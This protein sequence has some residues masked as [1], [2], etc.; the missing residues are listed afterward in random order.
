MTL[1]YKL[2]FQSLGGGKHNKPYKDGMQGRAHGNLLQANKSSDSLFPFHISERKEKH[3]QGNRSA[4]IAGHQLLWDRA[5]PTCD[6]PLGKLEREEGGPTP[7]R[8]AAPKISHTTQMAGESNTSGAASTHS[9]LVPA[10]D[11]ASAHRQEYSK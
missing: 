11:S 8:T 7:F 2:F 9:H 4:G 10:A 6:T 1:L 3:G 5:A